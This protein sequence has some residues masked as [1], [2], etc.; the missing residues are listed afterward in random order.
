LRGVL[1]RGEVKV[2]VVGGEVERE[3]A[4]GEIEGK[5]L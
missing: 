5:G 4:R 1:L 3:N 2:E